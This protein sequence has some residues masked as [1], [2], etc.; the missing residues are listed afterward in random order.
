MPEARENPMEARVGLATSVVM[1][2]LEL[3][4]IGFVTWVFCYLVCFQYLINGLQP[5]QATGI[6]LIVVYAIF[7]LMLL[8]PWLRLLQVIWTKPDLLRPADD[9]TTEKADADPQA[10][11]QYDA[12]ICDYEGAPL[13]CEKCRIYKPDR[14]HHCKE[15]GRCVRK[16]DHYCPWAGGI[17]GETTHKYFMQ[18][19]VYAALYTTYLWIVVAIFLA[20]RSKQTGSRP[21]T[22]IGAL[23][24]GI[25]FCIFTACMSYMTAYNLTIN[26]TSVEGIQRGG[27]SNIAFLVTKMPDPTLSHT[28]PTSSNSDD[29]A[30]EADDDW[31]V[32]R[33]VR[34]GSGRTF[35]VMQTK[36][37]QH[38]WATSSA[39]DWK[40]T[41]GSS[42]L[43]WFLPLKHSPCK[44]KS[45]SGEFRWGEVVYEMAAKYQKD[46]PGAELALLEGR[47]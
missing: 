45:R 23:V 33:T 30:P 6:A 10:M 42:P 4:A 43:D 18:F 25:L 35:V 40:D 26:Y 2:L 47:R 11:E 1:P 7:L 13:F 15:L 39:Q 32:L 27:V 12:Y 21:G 19:L 29:K 5:R 14:T 44:Q 41:M 38:P 31:P 20:E 28:P 22:W 9:P 36:P 34:R 8:I 37:F 3:G 46:N 24:V 17:I 16:M